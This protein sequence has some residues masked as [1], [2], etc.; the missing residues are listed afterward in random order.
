MNTSRLS[1][2]TIIGILFFNC[3]SYDDDSYY[4]PIYLQ[5]QDALI[6]ENNQNYVV[7]D[8]IFLEL[9][10]SRYLKEEGYTEL[11]DIYE[12]TGAEQFL[13]DI[14]MS[15]FSTLANEYRFINVDSPFLISEKGNLFPD[16]NRVGATFDQNTNMYESKVGII[17]AE[18]G[19]Y[20]LDMDIIF[21]SSDEPFDKI[22]L[23]IEHN[24]SNEDAE[25]FTF[26][27]TQ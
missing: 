17:L 19:E 27:V 23:I 3:T 2:I 15:K 24:F 21:I 20:K 9:N 11:L 14:D 4:S 16:A 6:F 8:T 10:F 22:R 18:E 12:T 13:Y 5:L 7:G 26:S 1:L 25:R